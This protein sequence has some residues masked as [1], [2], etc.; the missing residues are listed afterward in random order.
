MEGEIEKASVFTQQISAFSPKKY[1]F[2]LLNNCAIL[3]EVYKDLIN[4][5]FVCTRIVKIN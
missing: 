4:Y 2:N 3:I 1:A 5:G